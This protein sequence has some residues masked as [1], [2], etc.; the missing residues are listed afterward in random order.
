MFPAWEHWSKMGLDTTYDCWHGAYSAFTRWRT[1]L[2]E[3]AGYLV[4][5][6]PGEVKPGETY[7]RDPRLTYPVTFIDWGHVTE[8]NLYGKWEKTPDDPLIVLIA[9]SDCDGLI[10]PEQASPL[11]DRLEQLLP[12]LEGD[13]GG[14]IGDYRS[15]T[16]EFITGLREA[17]ADGQPVEFL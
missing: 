12:L 5:P 8:D 14:H 16:Q 9:H 2:A 1:K 15:K 10:Y 3:I 7:Q 6:L 11:A 4:L 13:G 17:I